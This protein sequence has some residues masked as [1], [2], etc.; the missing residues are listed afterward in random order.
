M[1]IGWDFITKMPYYYR[2]ADV[3]VH[4]SLSECCSLVL[5]EA[6]ACGV[7]IVVTDKIAVYDPVGDAGLHFQPRN[8]E[9]LAEKIIRLLWNN[10]LRSK[11]CERGLKR[12]SEL[13]LTWKT[14]S[15]R[16]RDLYLSLM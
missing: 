12:I 15:E 5:I 2:S 14:A 9:D 3:C 16:Y 6:M 10:K 1:M 4:T 13:G 7:P 8:S 11:M